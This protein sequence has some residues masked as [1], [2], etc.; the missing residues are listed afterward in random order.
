MA[1]YGRSYSSYRGRTPKWKIILS[2]FLALV[3]V[4]SVGYLAL[5]RYI[6]YDE[7]ALPI[8]CCPA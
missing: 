8:S 1:G 3:I 6:V 5:E 4:V 7:T 2:V